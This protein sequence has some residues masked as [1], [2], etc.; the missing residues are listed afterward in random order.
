[1]T[2]Q[3]GQSI[4]HAAARYAEMHASHSGGSRCEFRPEDGYPVCD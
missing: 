4:A 1:M 2:P 3:A